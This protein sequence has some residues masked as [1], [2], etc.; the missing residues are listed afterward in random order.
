MQTF[1]PRQA[2]FL[3]VALV[4]AWLGV[5]LAFARLAGPYR[6]VSDRLEGLAVGGAVFGLLLAVA[7]VRAPYRLVVLPSAIAALGAIL[8][9]LALILRDRAHETGVTMAIVAGLAA[10]I[11]L[12]EFRRLDPTAARSAAR[13]QRSGRSRPST[14]AMDTGMRPDDGP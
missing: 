13:A 2:L 9:A 7:V 11:S 14:G 3:R 8:I 6:P 4:G 1:L 10:G 12:L 5:A